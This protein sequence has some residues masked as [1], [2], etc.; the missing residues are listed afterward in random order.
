V[1]LHE[2]PRGLI[3]RNK[4]DRRRPRKCWNGVV[5][6]RKGDWGKGFLG[7]EVRERVVREVEAKVVMEGS[8][9]SAG[10]KF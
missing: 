5:C 9:R 7:R 10:S 6:T 3:V 8:R 2:I 4:E 1:G